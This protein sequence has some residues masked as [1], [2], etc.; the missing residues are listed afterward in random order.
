VTD[1]YTVRW[2]G[3]PVLDELNRQGWL[4][5]NIFGTI[6]GVNWIRTNNSFPMRG[7]SD[8]SILMPYSNGFARIN[9]TIQI[10]VGGAQGAGPTAFD[11]ANYANQPNRDFVTTTD[12]SNFQ[13]TTASCPAC[14]YAWTGTQ[15][16]G[17][18][19][20]GGGYLNGMYYYVG[21]WDQ[22]AII[23]D[24]NEAN[25]YLLKT[26]ASA[27]GITWHDMNIEAPFNLSNH[28]DI[29]G[30]NLT[31]LNGKMWGGYEVF[32]GELHVWAG[33]DFA[34][35]IDHPEHFAF[36]GTSWRTVCINCPYGTHHHFNWLIFRNRILM[37]QSIPFG[38]LDVGLDEYVNISTKLWAYG[39][40]D[41]CLL[42]GYPCL[43]GGTCVDGYL[44]YTC[45]CSGGYSGALCQTDINE[46]S[47]NPCQNG[48]T[49]QD[50][51]SGFQCTC[52]AGYSGASC[53]TDINECSSS[54]CHN[55]LVCADQVNSYTCL[56]GSSA[57][58][59][60]SI[61]V[62]AFIP[63]IIMSFL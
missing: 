38:L 13:R 62:V 9:G 17:P 33:G 60:L 25:R 35:D 21:F 51:L 57:A 49:C 8:G 46:C 53:Q 4:E 42:E 29:N 58:W 52:Q 26:Y 1:T 43:H 63:M 27:D 11:D 30:N 24:D 47:S 12:F 54:P 39:E 7:I 31:R 18:T 41:D 45:L 61:A 50:H 44:T 59:H 6:D 19:V 28:I 32:N 15:G 37:F 5:T 23:T 36:N 16:G 56:L 3:F 14:T 22:G 34:F 20:S 10:F 48:G 55:G 2:G 40:A